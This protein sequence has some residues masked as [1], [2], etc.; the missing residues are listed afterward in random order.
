MTNG[1]DNPVGRG[2]ILT[3][4]AHKG[5][6]GKTT[7]AYELGAILNGILIDLDFHGGGATH[8]WG[9]DPRGAKTAP[10]LDALERGPDGRP[11]R[12]KRRPN[13]P[14]LIPSHPDLG[15]ARLDAEEFADC[16]EAWAQTFEGRPLVID[17][18]PG[19]HPTTDGALQVAD[20]IVAPVP[21]GRRELGATRS[22]LAELLG[23][24]V[25][26][27]PMMAPPLPPDWWIEAL[28]EFA[29]AE[30]VHLAPPIS[31]HRWL[32]RRVLSTAVSLQRNAGQKTLIAA[33]EYRAVAQRSAELWQTTRT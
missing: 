33:D 17:T 26:L 16:L 12:P 8:L 6:V 32:R 15:A 18:H 23:Y 5:G 9:F 29:K 1:D 21:P 3:V 14:D 10:L 20:L 31:E 28:Q 4:T 2:A 27:V 19:A 11:P 24:P 25:L 13:K 30:T 22:M 7:L